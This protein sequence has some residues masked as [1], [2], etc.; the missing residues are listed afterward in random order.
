MSS[1][2]DFFLQLDPGKAKKIDR[3]RLRAIKLQ[4]LFL[5]VPFMSGPNIIK[6]AKKDQL[7]NCGCRRLTNIKGKI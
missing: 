3:K 5:G 1:R 2:C 4:R 7:I 6:M